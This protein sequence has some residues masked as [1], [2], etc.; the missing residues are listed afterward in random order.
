MANCSPSE[1][2]HTMSIG[3][4]GVEIHSLIE[5]DMPAYK[6]KTKAG[7]VL[8]YAN[9]YYTD[10]LGQKQHKCKR[11]FKTQ[12]EAKDWERMF[13]EGTSKDPTI[14]T[15][16]LIEKY[17]AD[18][19]TRLKPSTMATKQWIFDLK[20]TP[21]FGKVRICDI[22]PIMVRRWQNELLDYRDEKGQAYT[23]TYLKTVHNQLSALMNYAVRYYG[24]RYNPCL[25]AGSIG[26]GKAEEMQIWT[27]DQFNQLL[28]QL[29]RA[30]YRL[31][32]KLLFYTGMRKG[33]LLALTPDDIMEDRI[34]INKNF[35]VVNGEDLIQ[36]PK[37]DRS[38]RDVTVPVTLIQEAKDYIG[39]ILIEHDERLFLFKKHGLLAAFNAAIRRAG[40]PKIRIHDLRHSHAAMLIDM[41]VPIDEISRRLGHE[42]TRTTWDTYAHLYPGKDVLL[43]DQLN[44][45]ILSDSEKKDAQEAD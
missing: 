19:A 43:A 25:T 4:F 7:K 40:L 3:L 45:A 11:G 24:L 41:G 9:F 8:W 6:Y 29:K 35:Q 28:P 31:A 32:F 30:D 42:S 15:G 17:M 34:R 27:R 16:A 18:C 39:S 36:T 10:W 22:D 20:I 13:L 44:N 33:E 14:L 38:I 21:F 26:K 37:T 1:Q 5:V 12:R 23:Q 2:A